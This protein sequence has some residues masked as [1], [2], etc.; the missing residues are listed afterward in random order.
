MKKIFLILLVVILSFFVFRFVLRVKN[1][2]Y[3]QIPESSV[4][5]DEWTNVWH[6][7]SIRSSGIPAAWSMLPPYYKKN[8]G[9]TEKFTVTINDK[10]PTLIG[11]SNFTKPAISIR[12]IDFGKDAKFGT[13]VRDVVIVQP[14]LDHPPFGALVL[15]SLVSKSVKTFIDLNPFEFRKTSIYL[16]VLSAILLLILSWQITGNIWIGLAASLIYFTVPSYILVE[17]YA[18]LENVLAPIVLGFLNILYLFK[19]YLRNNRVGI[20]LAI[21]LGILGGLA[22]LTKITGWIILPLGWFIFWNWKIEKKYYLYFSLPLIILGSLYFVWGMFL[23]PKLFMEIL[24]TQG[25]RGFIGSINLIVA[26]Y[27]V[28]ILNFPLDG[29]WIGGFLSLLL[30]QKKNEYIPIF[31]TVS[32]IILSALLLGGANYPWYYI[33][34]VP[35]MALSSAIFIYEVA[36]SPTIANVIVFFVIYFS[37]SF[38]WGFGVYRAALESTMYQ[39]PFNV[40]RLLL[41]LVL[42]PGFILSWIFKDQKYRK[43]W[44][45]FI[46]IIFVLLIYLNERSIYYILNNW[47]KLPSLYTPGTF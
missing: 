27:R 20:L 35:L 30:I 23:D 42:I 18:L 31:A 12:Q 47:G 2:N 4:I 37:S 7:L 45:Y 9:G 26:A 36:T 24:N 8:V 14:Y 19:K 32:A 11:F 5:L 1:T 16:S 38:Y 6:G 33:H 10:A 15:S 21:A 3:D 28:G 39:Q 44:L 34:A 41:I 29:W 22:A 17:R 43:Y 13:G 25:S 40:Y 46:V